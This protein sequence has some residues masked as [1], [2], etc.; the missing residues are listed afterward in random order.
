ME[1]EIRLAKEED[2]QNILAIYS[3]YITNSEITFEYE[4]PTLI[5]F[6]N[7]IKMIQSK[8]P[9]LVCTYQGKIVAYAYVSSFHERAAYMYNVDW[10]VYV[11]KEYHSHHIASALYH[12]L[13]KLL[14]LMGY[15]NV[16]SLVTSHN[17]AS[18]KLHEALGFHICGT[19]KNCGYK[20]RKWLDVTL[21]EKEIQ[22]IDGETLPRTIHNLE[23]NDVE[24]IL[25]E[26]C[27]EIK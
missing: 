14:L 20:N 18:E 11:Q 25:Q 16:Y 3:P 19:W 1:W 15:R 27:K 10:S 2:T 13:E 4:I 24:A 5:E 6:Q 23:K 9:Y 22:S 8:Y 7:R 26:S 21:Y 12:A 17:K